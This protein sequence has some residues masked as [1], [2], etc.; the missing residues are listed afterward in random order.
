[1]QSPTELF[2]PKC[3]GQ[4]ALFECALANAMATHIQIYVGQFGS[5]LLYA[6]VCLECGDTTLRPHP[7]DMERIRQSRERNRERGKM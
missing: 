1:M 4:Q 3:G 2:C 6:C 7:N 5:A